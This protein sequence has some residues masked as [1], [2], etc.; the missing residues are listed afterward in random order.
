MEPGASGGPAVTAVKPP[1]ATTISFSNEL[2]FFVNGVDGR[3]W[4]TTVAPGSGW[5]PT[6]WQC[7]GHLAAAAFVAGSTLTSAFA[8]QGGDRAVWAAITTGAGWDMQRVGGTVIDGPGIAISPTSWTVV[9]EGVNQALW[10]DTSTSTTGGF[11]F[12]PWTSAGGMLTDGAAAT[13]LLTQ[14]SNP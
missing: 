8:C 11:S 7:S 10:Q 4:E 14:A 1:V 6:G 2:T 9:A 12:G 3:V 5:T 13:A